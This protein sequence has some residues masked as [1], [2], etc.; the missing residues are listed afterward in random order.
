[1]GYLGDHD[2]ERSYGFERPGT[3]RGDRQSVFGDRYSFEGH[4]S[5]ADGRS[6]DRPGTS[7]DADFAGKGLLGNYDLAQ[8]MLQG[9]R[10]EW[11]ITLKIAFN[12]GLY[13]KSVFLEWIFN[14]SFKDF[15]IGVSLVSVGTGG[16]LK[17]SNFG[18]SLTLG[19]GNPTE[20]ASAEM[21]VTAKLG[22]GFG[23]VVV[24]REEG[25]D[26]GI[27]VGKPGVEFNMSGDTYIIMGDEG[28]PNRTRLPF[29]P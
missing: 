26:V 20:A 13:Q 1:M 19:G 24:V 5:A 11:A 25:F 22:A 6:F 29:I 12:V 17:L 18:A 4:Y 23:P 10:K 15:V 2:L 14:E 21:S 27:G 8:S 16:K 9:T 3:S 28:S 7:R